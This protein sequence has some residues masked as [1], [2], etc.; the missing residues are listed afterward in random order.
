MFCPCDENA[1]TLYIWFNLASEKNHK[2]IVKMV[3]NNRMLLSLAKNKVAKFVVY[4]FS[5][6]SSSFGFIKTVARKK[7]FR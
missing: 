7:N 1:G 2:C 6:S 5:S 3:K 4:F